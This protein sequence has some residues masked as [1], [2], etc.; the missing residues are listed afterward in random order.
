MSKDIINQIT[1]TKLALVPL[2]FIGCDASY[3]EIMQPP[4]SP[5][6]IK[7]STTTSTPDAH[8]VS[9]FSEDSIYESHNINV[10]NQTKELLVSKL[11]T[12]YDIHDIEEIS[13][14]EQALI[15]KYS[16]L[17]NGPQTSSDAMSINNENT[18]KKNSKSTDSPAN[19]IDFSS[20]CNSDGFGGI[21]CNLSY[22]PIDDQQAFIVY[23]VIDLDRNILSFPF[24]EES[25]TIYM[26]TAET[27]GSIKIRIKLKDSNGRTLI[28]MWKKAHIPAT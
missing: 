26:H 23:E 20:N 19:E 3:R 10:I 14:V 22:T 13:K 1:K 9:N 5:E 12:G 4:S 21:S 2:L 17:N 15:T 18:T 28:S 24:A 16:E 25:E 7:E 8:I 11:N 6:E 27:E